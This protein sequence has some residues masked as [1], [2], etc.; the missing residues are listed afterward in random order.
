MIDVTFHEFLMCIS[1]VFL[2]N[3]GYV[4]HIKPTFFFFFKN[5]NRIYRKEIKL[6]V[7]GQIWKI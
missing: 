6:K 4:T 3:N 7:K 5:T 1:F 2:V